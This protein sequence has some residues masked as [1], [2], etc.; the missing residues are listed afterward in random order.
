MSSKNY[1]VGFHYT[2]FAKVYVT[3]DSQDEADKMVYE[4]LEDY[5]M[6]DNAKVFD[7]DY[8]VDYSE[9]INDE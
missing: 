8:S 6:L 4:M 9:E 3:A 7:R 1:V 5:G 2:E